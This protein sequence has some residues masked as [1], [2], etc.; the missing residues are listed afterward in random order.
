LFA[1]GFAPRC[2]HAAIFVAAAAVP[3]A[4]ATCTPRRPPHVFCAH[5]HS[6]RRA[7]ALEALGQKADALRDYK[8]ALRLNPSVG[9]AVAGVRRLE[10]ALGLPSSIKEAPASGRG[11]SGANGATG[12]T[13]L[14]SGMLQLSEEDHR[15]FTEV[16]QR[17]KD[18]AKQKNMAQAQHNAAAR[19]K[20]S[21]ELTLAQVQALADGT[22]TYRTVGRMFLATPQ[23]EVKTHLT[24]RLARAEAK[25]RVCATALEHLSKQEQEAD[26]NFVELMTALQKKGARGNASAAAGGARTE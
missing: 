4:A 18:V 9:E 21:A 23:P 24:E 20:R 26:A 22:A 3:C 15:Q 14:P 8:D 2:S 1:D 6:A 5:L 7:A 16:R 25:L 11:G 17:V 13:L 19:E 10:A 12:T